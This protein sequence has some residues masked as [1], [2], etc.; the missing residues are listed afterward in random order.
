MEFGLRLIHEIIQLNSSVNNGTSIDLIWQE[1][2][3]VVKM[4][5]AHVPL[6]LKRL[7]H[8]RVTSITALMRTK[9]ST[10]N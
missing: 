1:G 9:R 2:F 4:V 7:G 8:S 10:R 5:F 3:L 6:H